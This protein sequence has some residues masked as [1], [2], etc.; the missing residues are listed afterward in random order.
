MFPLLLY[1]RDINL[2]YEGLIISAFT[3][4]KAKAPK[5]FQ[6]CEELLMFTVGNTALFTLLWW[7]ICIPCN[8]SLCSV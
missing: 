1:V 5:L 4:V 6:V 8:S 7:V 3:T 2:I